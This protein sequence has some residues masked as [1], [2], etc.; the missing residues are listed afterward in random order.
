MIVG[1]RSCTK[2]F[3][4]KVFIKEKNMTSFE[5]AALL[6]STVQSTTVSTMY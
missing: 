1:D 2:Q 6:N 3:L 5:C 4:L